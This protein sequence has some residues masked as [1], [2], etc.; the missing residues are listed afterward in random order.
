MS[1]YSVG[2]FGTAHIGT[3]VI[4]SLGGRPKLVR[5]IQHVSNTEQ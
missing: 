3:S 4:V 5:M 1:P 2:P